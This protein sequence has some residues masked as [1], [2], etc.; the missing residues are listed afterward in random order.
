M[1]ELI[2]AD[3]GKFSMTGQD[4]NDYTVMRIEGCNVYAIMSYC[5]IEGVTVHGLYKSYDKACESLMNFCEYN[6]FLP[7]DNVTHEIMNADFSFPDG[8]R[9]MADYIES[10]W[11]YT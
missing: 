3:E 9:D 8:I 7:D 10:V 11:R 1:I 2:F 5:E 4:M 6:L